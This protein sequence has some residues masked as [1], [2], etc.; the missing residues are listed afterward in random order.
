MIKIC[1]EFACRTSELTY[2]NAISMGEIEIRELVSSR[3]MAT[4]ACIGTR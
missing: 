4:K 2:V 1:N 3:L